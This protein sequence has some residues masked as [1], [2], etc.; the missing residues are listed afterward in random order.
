MIRNQPVILKK[1]RDKSVRNRHHW[2]FSGSVAQYPEFEDGDILPVVSHEGEILG[3]GYFNRLCSLCGRIVSF[4]DKE[5]LESVKEK[6]ARAVE[7]RKQLLKR[8]N[9]CR[10]INAEGDALPGLV[11]DQ[12]NETL[13]L[14]ISTLGMVKLKDVVVKWLIEKIQPRTIYEKS[15]SPAR[16]E[17][18][19][20][21]FRGLIFGDEVEEVEIQEN[22]LNFLINPLRGQKTGFFLDQR[23]M[24]ELL[25]NFASGLKVLD[26]F[27]Y[28]GAFSIYAL[29]GGAR[30][31]TLVESSAFALDM[32]QRN[33]E[34]NGFSMS[35]VN[36]I[37]SD[38]FKFLSQENLP[39][40]LIICD[41]PS[42]AHRKNELKRAYRGMKQL[43]R[44]LFHR[45]PSGSLL[46]TFSCSYYLTEVLFQKLIFQAAQEEDRSVR[47]IQRHRLA[48]DHPLNIFHPESEYLKGFLLAVD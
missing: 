11:V 21:P 26:L 37:K 20:A 12:Y 7:L 15:D 6:L 5:P 35:K 23:S 9:A 14:Q 17:E 4:G 39:Y 45:I 28:T 47:I 40:D 41:P 3:Y 31:V 42:F 18:G 2:I 10:L 13:V 32:A 27:S 30:E 46:M 48:I 29:S 34:I 44:L 1:G 25:R 38:A 8:T 43:H 33:F 19:L 22:G 36:L 24:R 16:R